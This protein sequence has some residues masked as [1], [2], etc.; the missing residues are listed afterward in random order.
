MIAQ[1]HIPIV[2]VPFGIISLSQSHLQWN[3]A[4]VPP[5]EFVIVDNVRVPNLVI[6][7]DAISVFDC[8]ST[9]VGTDDTWLYLECVYVDV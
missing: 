4:T 3:Y 1:Y 6:S 9:G 2:D 5:V 8:V 7:W